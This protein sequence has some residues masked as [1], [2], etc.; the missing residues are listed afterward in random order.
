MKNRQALL[1]AAASIALFVPPAGAKTFPSHPVLLAQAGTND[2]VAAAEAA[3]EAARAKL[4]QAMAS[5]QG[6]EEARQELNAA[7]AALAQARATAG[8]APAGTEQGQPPAATDQ[9][10]PPTTPAPPPPPETT[11]APPPSDQNANPP[12]D[13]NGPPKGKRPNFK[14]G[15]NQNETQPAPTTTVAP[16]PTTTVAPPPPPTTPAPETTAPPAA[17]ENAAPPPPAEQ[18]APPTTA[19]PPPPPPPTTPAPAAGQGAPPPAAGQPPPTTAAP[20]PTTTAAPEPTI[21]LPPPPQLEA[22]PPPPPPPAATQGGNFNLQ[23]FKSRPKFG[24]L[25]PNAP[26]TAPPP[27][28]K[29]EDALQNGAVI[30]APGGRIILKDQGQVTVEHDDSGRFVRQGDK[31]NNAR[32]DNGTETTTVNR[33]DGSSIVTVRDQS[34]NIIQRYRK[35][36]DGSVT[37]LIGNEQQPNIVGR[38][39]GQ[40]PQ[41][42]PPRP[43]P[44]PQLNLR[45]GPLQLTIP[46]NQYIVDSSRANEQQLQQTLGAP[47][48]ERVERAYSLE[49]IERNGRLRDKVRR[50]DFD[51]I[52]FDT[53]QATVPDDQIAKMQAI[54]DAIRAIVDRDPST[55]ILIEGHT[56]AVGSDLANLALSDRRA[57]TVAQILSYYFGIPPENLVTQGYGEQYLKVPTTAANQENRRVAFRNITPLLRPQG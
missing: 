49:E 42:P 24:A 3:V 38:I 16:P 27:L 12:A 2:A 11:A 13:Q 21:T 40:K 37:V 47:P 9:N 22:P 57:E 28:P 35:N 18:A 31:V 56:D 17:N 39:F 25:P 30:Q 7:L 15:Q 36:K 23:N 53:G 6:V 14:P 34:G 8:S 48:V 26:T 44:P 5:G 4:Q 41:L 33:P 29:S 50:I 1:L 51:T 52:T 43:L 32:T 10:P 45:L 46:Q 55:V 54:G 20:G 19:P